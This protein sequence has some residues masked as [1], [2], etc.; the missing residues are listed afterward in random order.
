MNYLLLED[1]DGN[2]MEAAFLLEE[3]AEEALVFLKRHLA[4]EETKNK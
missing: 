3:N 1:V 4:I 2:S